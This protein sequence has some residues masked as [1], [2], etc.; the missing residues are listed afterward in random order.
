MKKLLIMT[1]AMAFVMG[2]SSCDSKTEKKVQAKKETVAMP[3]LF[4]LDNRGQAQLGI[5][6]LGHRGRI[7]QATLVLYKDGSAFLANSASNPNLTWK[8]VEEKK[9]MAK[10]GKGLRYVYV[11]SSTRPLFRDDI[12]EEF[13][14]LYIMEDGKIYLNTDTYDENSL[15]GK[16][17]R[18]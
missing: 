12:G 6:P 10:G 8:Y 5:K 9:T 11:L 2:M 17:R 4:R 15:I 1:M 16:V 3:E 18:F 13:Y 7:E 14:D